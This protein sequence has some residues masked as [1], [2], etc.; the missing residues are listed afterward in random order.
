[1][2]AMERKKITGD[3]SLVLKNCSELLK[4][5]KTPR[6]LLAAF[7]NTPFCVY[8]SDGKNARL[9][10]GPAEFPDEISHGN[11]KGEDLVSKL[12]ENLGI[13]PELIAEHVIWKHGMS[14]L[15]ARKTEEEIEFGTPFSK[16]FYAFFE[17]FKDLMDVV[18]FK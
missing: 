8:E 6:E 10:Y 17:A 5:A 2:K 15:I 4:T 9:L 1:M 12:S 18:A 13:A 16:A 11:K 3:M 7:E 14:L